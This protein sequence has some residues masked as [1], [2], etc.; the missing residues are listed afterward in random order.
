MTHPKLSQDAPESLSVQGCHANMVLAAL[1]TG[2]ATAVRVPLVTLA[3]TVIK[4]GILTNNRNSLM[5]Q[6]L[7]YYPDKLKRHS[8]KNICK[9][10]DQCMKKPS[11]TMTNTPNSKTIHWYTKHT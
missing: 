10:T 5:V 3:K 2:L 1:V 9:M 6:Y 8:N 11:G 4:V 7:L